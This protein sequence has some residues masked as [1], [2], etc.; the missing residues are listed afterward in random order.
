M[1][2]GGCM[3]V[4]AVVVGGGG[5]WLGTRV[6]GSWDSGTSIRSQIGSIDADRPKKDKK[7]SDFRGPPLKFVRG[8]FRLVDEQIQRGMPYSTTAI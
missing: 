7:V 8:P 6:P 3:Q 2:T 5:G 1:I 4:H